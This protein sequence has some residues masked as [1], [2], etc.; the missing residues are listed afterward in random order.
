MTD[1][2]KYVDRLDAQLKIT[3]LSMTYSIQNPSLRDKI[4][5]KINI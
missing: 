1:W 2:K 5:K 4:L 3:I